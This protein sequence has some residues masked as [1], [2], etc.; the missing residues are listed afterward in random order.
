MLQKIF[1]MENF[2]H[3][4]HIPNPYPGRKTYLGCITPT[5]DFEPLEGFIVIVNDDFDGPVLDATLGSPYSFRRNNGRFHTPNTVAY[6]RIRQEPPTADY[7]SIA[8]YAVSQPPSPGSDEHTAVLK[9]LKDTKDINPPID[10]KVI[11]GPFNHYPHSFPGFIRIILDTLSTNNGVPSGGHEDNGK[12]LNSSTSDGI[13]LK[14]STEV[15]STGH[16]DDE[17]E[18][19]TSNTGTILKSSAEV[20]SAGH[21]CNERKL[22]TSTNDDTK[23]ETSHDDGNKK[24]DSGEGNEGRGEKSVYGSNLS[25]KLWQDILFSTLE[26]EGPMFFGDGFTATALVDD[27][28]LTSKS[29]S[30]NDHILS[31]IQGRFKAC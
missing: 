20:P 6:K 14:T 11:S 21:D 16:D 23:L 17:R 4:D 29:P 9:L 1:T 30:I 22:K 15:P 12:E 31:K 26:S 24:N 18:I 5:N 25:P 7:L 13:E 2:I 3:K 10:W 8:V 19:K 28:F 27:I